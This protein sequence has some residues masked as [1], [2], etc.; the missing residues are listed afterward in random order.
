M[1]KSTDTSAPLPWHVV[2]AAIQR[3]KKWFLEVFEFDDR[4]HN[5][6][7]MPVSH[8]EM[9]RQLCVAIVSGKVRARELRSKTANG[10]WMD[11]VPDDWISISTQERH[12]EQWHQAMMHIIKHHFIAD[13]CEIIN[14]P[15]LNQGRADLG[16][17]KTGLPNL[18]VEVGSTSL[19]KTWIN[20]LT[21]PNSAFLFVPSEQCT[22][23]FKT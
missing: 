5:Q 20:L 10:L 12:G 1:Q 11:D 13:G 15:R 23:E 22:L 9:V 6:S 2:E 3:E 17:Y 18:Y 14:E 21:M 16:V 19:C 4:G 8:D 7:T